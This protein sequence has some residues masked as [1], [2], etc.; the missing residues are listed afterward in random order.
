MAWANL[1]PS[2]IEFL[3][4]IYTR[5]ET[6]GLTIPDATTEN[7]G[8]VEL[9][10]DEEASVGTPNK[11]I[12][13]PQLQSKAG[14]ATY[15]NQS[16]ANTLSVTDKALSPGTLPRASTNQRGISRQATDDEALLGSV[17][18]IFVNPAQARRAIPDASEKVKGKSRFATPVEMANRNNGV[19]IS[20][21]ML[22]AVVHAINSLPTL[23][24]KGQEKIIK[25]TD[26]GAVLIDVP[27]DS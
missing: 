25:L 17:G 7:K 1:D 27:S 8:V 23:P 6:L 26:S 5:R 11:V 16:E 18:T 2:I 3:I 19:V 4:D 14:G 21:S 20:P 22:S 9:A 13:A 10:T 15:A 12:T 24:A